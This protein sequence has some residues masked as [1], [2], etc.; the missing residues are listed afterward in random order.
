M[1]ERQQIINALLNVEKEEDFK[2]YLLACIN[3]MDIDTN[4]PLTIMTNGDLSF[5]KKMYPN[6]TLIN[7]NPDNN[8]LFFK[9]DESEN[10]NHLTYTFSIYN[11]KK[12]DF[13]LGLGKDEYGVYINQI[14]K[15]NI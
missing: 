10:K 4:K 11:D 9:V 15:T 8:L 7:F 3:E 12:A 6:I 5:I 2:T 14:D 13:E 1:T